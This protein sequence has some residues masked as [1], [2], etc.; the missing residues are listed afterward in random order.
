MS[1][2]GDVRV[3]ARGITTVA[4]HNIELR[5]HPVTGLVDM[6]FTSDDYRCTEEDAVW[7][8]EQFERFAQGRSRLGFLV[9]CGRLASTDGGWRKTLADYFRRPAP[10]RTTIA[11]YSMS[12]LVR[13]TVDMFA[14]ATPDIEGKAFRSEADARAW[15]RERGFE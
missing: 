14:A 1:D 11:W 7:L 13:V 5:L 10:T 3:D 2:D 9:D 6:R 15:L 12:L 8:L 4:D